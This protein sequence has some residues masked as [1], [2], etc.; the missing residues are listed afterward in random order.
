[1][2]SYELV[3]A[4]S[5][6]LAI[7]IHGPKLN[8]SD[9]L[10]DS[11]V[12]MSK[13]RFQENDILRM[14]MKMLSEFSWNVNPDTPQHF[15]YSFVNILS[16]F[17]EKLHDRSFEVQ[18]S[19]LSIYII[20]VILFDPQFNDDDSPSSLACAAILI[21]WNH[22]VQLENSIRAKD[23]TCTTDIMENYIDHC[24]TYN[25]LVHIQPLFSHGLVDQTTI[26]SLVSEMNTY[27][28]KISPFIKNV[29]LC[30]HA[31]SS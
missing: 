15:I 22:V 19:E 23:S 3:T 2:S 7:K 13:N 1:M 14:E 30:K 20:E 28:K 16:H 6:Y 9:N 18:L 4:T 25:P 5:L 10:I 21:A 17:D 11:F 31:L 12:R 26:I 24:P 29:Q 8:T 27:L